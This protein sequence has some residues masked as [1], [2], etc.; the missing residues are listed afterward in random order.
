MGRGQSH[1]LTD[2]PEVD[3]PSEPSMFPFW[4]NHTRERSS[5]MRHVIGSI[6]KGLAH[7]QEKL[8]NPSEP[9]IH[10]H[11]HFNM[12]EYSDSDSG[13]NT[14]KPSNPKLRRPSERSDDLQWSI[15]PALEACKLFQAN[16]NNMGPESHRKPATWGW[17][18]LGTFPEPEG[19]SSKTQNRTRLQKAA[20]LEPRVEAATFEAI[21]NAAES[22]PF[23]WPGLGEWPR[24]RK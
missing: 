1:T 16:E 18:G 20:A 2:Y 19:P 12:T 24:S 17:P 4:G 5:R 15:S 7:E 6:R 13:H 9:A 8:F 10:D 3:K 14:T 22:E 11:E 21:D 23:G